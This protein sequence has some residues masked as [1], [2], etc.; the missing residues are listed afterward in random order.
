VQLERVAPL[1]ERSHED[2]QV[3]QCLLLMLLPATRGITTV[4]RL[5]S[6][7]RAHCP[8][9]ASCVRLWLLEVVRGRLRLVSAGNK[10]AAQA[11]SISKGV[12]QLGGCC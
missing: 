5:A 10:R 3:G 1:L 7:Q 12:E 6:L 4:C 8:G 9:Q 11:P 2:V